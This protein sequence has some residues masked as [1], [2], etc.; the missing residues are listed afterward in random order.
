MLDLIL[1]LVLILQVGA[2]HFLVLQV[3]G[4]GFLGLPGP[5]PACLVGLGWAWL[6]LGLGLDF[7]GLADHRPR[8]AGFGFAF[9]GMAGP[10]PCLVGLHPCLADVGF[11]GL[12][13]R[14]GLV[15]GLCLVDLGQVALVLQ[16]TVSCNFLVLLFR[17]QLHLWLCFFGVIRMR[18]S[19]PRSVWIIVHQRNR[20]SMTRV[21]SP[22]PLTPH[23]P[24]RSWI[25]DPDP[26][27]PK[28]THP[29]SFPSLSASSCSLLFSLS[30]LTNSMLAP[31]GRRII[32]HKC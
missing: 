2:L 10:R 20:E 17:L 22:V 16:V 9:L 27:H 6:C 24:D 28:G 11:A 5:R 32:R 18:I 1:V 21:D 15:F 26:D 23:D 3:F 19:D 14:L 7:A 30:G 31:M 25:T 8:L 13:L 12:G 4:F 29:M